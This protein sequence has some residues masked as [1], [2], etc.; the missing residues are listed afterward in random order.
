MSWFLLARVLIVAAVGYAAALL[1]PL[2]VNLWM[3]V[4]FAG[5][6]ALLVVVFETRLRD[7]APS[8]VFGSILGGVIGLAIARG[9]EAGLF[10]TD[11]G[12]RRI[13]FL[14]SFL[15]IGAQMPSGGH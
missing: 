7:T 12:D 14:H 11:S 15:L 2:P 6:L 10:W 5:L 1:R 8:Q 3:N 13:E 9:I 4:G